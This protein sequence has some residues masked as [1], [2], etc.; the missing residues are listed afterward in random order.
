MP[1]AYAFVFEISKPCFAIVFEKKV[2]KFRLGLDQGQIKIIGLESGL[3]QGQGSINMRR[4]FI[5]LN[6]FGRVYSYSEFKG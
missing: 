1:D 3:D 2:V 5:V 6:K 4:E